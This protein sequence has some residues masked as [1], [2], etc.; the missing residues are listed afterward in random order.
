VGIL[1][2]Y[3]HLSPSVFSNIARLVR[4]IHFKANLLFE[5]E[6][7]FLRNYKLSEDAQIRLSFSNQKF[8]KSK[9][10]YSSPGCRLRLADFAFKKSDIRKFEYDG[11]H[12]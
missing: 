4:A 1:R 11:K 5:V 8:Y 3:S 12:G 6:E 7:V 9:H 2:I 10:R